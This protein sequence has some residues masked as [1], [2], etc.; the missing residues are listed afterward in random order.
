MIGFLMSI[1]TTMYRYINRV[2][3]LIK[4]NKIVN[5]FLVTETVGYGGYDM[6]SMPEFLQLNYKEKMRYR[7]KIFYK[8]TQLGEIEPVVI[9]A[10][11][12]VYR[13]SVS[14]AMGS[15]K[16]PQECEVYNVMMTPIVESFK[17]KQV[18]TE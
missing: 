13:L 17:A 5:V 7:T 1:R 10:D 15:M 3:N 4:S 6:K 9:D 8:V 14:V 12:L 11:A 18:L 2:A 16:H